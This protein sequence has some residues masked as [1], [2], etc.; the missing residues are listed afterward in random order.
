MNLYFSLPK[1]AKRIV[2]NY[3]S[4]QMINCYDDLSEKIPYKSANNTEIIVNRR[5]WRVE[6]QLETLFFKENMLK[7][8]ITGAVYPQ[9]NYNIDPYSSYGFGTI[10]YTVKCREID[11]DSDRSN[12]DIG[13]MPIFMEMIEVLLS[14]LKKE[15]QYL[16]QFFV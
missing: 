16:E 14:Q 2:N 10:V 12:I 1:D 13:D 6:V 3:Q 8:Y 11:I 5:V 4:L 7:Y 15:K 9:F